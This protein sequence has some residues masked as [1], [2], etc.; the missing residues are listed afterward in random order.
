MKLQEKI[1]TDCLQGYPA[2]HIPVDPVWLTDITCDS[3]NVGSG[4]LFV[5]IEGLASDGHAYI[6]QAVAKG[7]AA[8]IAQKP[9]PE[10][11]VPV[12]YVEDSRH[13]L[14]YIARRFYGCPDQSLTMLGVTGT[15]GKTTVTYLLESVLNECG[16]PCGLLGTV[17]YRWP[18]KKK[19]A[20]HTTPDAVHLFKLLREMADDG[21]QAVAMETSSHALALNRVLGIQYQ[22]GIFT[23]LT[24][25][26]M[27]FHKNVEAYAEAK[28]RL[29]KQIAGDGIAVINGDDAYAPMMAASSAGRIVR[30]GEQN[31]E[32]EY[33]IVRSVSDEHGASF[34]LKHHGGTD[35]FQ[36]HL[37]GHFN[38]FNA[39]AAVIAAL[40]MKLNIEDIRRALTKMRGVPGRMEGL[41]SKQGFLVVVDYA[42]TPDALENALHT[43]RA[44]T[45]GRLITVFGCGGDRDRGKRPQMGQA[46]SGISDSVIVTSDNPRTEDPHSIIENILEGIPASAS[47]KVIEDRESAIREAIMSAEKGDTVMIAGKGHEDY[48]ILGSKTIHFDDREVALKYINE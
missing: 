40:E 19:K 18:G 14:A 7:A 35:V 28:A 20:S 8:V 23:N 45:R 38:V 17:S 3:R 31:R 21:V 5:A 46:A 1:L 10:M 37:L 44:F 11:Q 22:A 2:T 6:A 39:A 27:D 4:S 12:L 25:D 9:V 29:F 34:S 43:A 16:L 41:R 30:F 26:H 47:M 13:A 36:T 15:N 33:Q 32:A 48:Q 24:R 42:H